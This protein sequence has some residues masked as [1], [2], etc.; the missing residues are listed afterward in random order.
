MIDDKIIQFINNGFKLIIKKLGEVIEV[1]KKKDQQINVS[2]P[3]VNVNIPNVVVP[4]IKVPK[5]E[6]PEIKIPEINIP[7]IN[8]PTPVIPKPV[9]PVVNIPAPIVNV[10]EAN[11]TIQPP[12]IEFPEKMKVDRIDELI[13][14]LDLLIDKKSSLFDDV[15]SQH[16]LPISVFDSK[17]NQI[18]DFGGEYSAPSVVGIFNKNGT[19]NVQVNVSTEAKQDDIITELQSLVA[20]NF[21][22]EAT[23]LEI[24]AAV[25]GGG[26]PVT[27]TVGRKVVASTDTAIALGTGEFKTLWVAG[28]AANTDVIVIGD[29]GVVHT[30]ASRNGT[31]MFPNNVMTITNGRLQDW[32]INGAEGNGVSF[33]YTV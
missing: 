2:P 20:K 29:S 11:I 31:P 17:G 6:L 16:T 30:V 26:A 18:N 19:Q 13:S 15:S 4:E 21:A 5:I 9:A 8:I 12:G 10:P 27:P 33:T 32:F 3:E 1:I 7:E 14:K 28:L 24:L 22:T 25:G 23:A